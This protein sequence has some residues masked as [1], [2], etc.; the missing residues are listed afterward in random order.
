MRSLS[1][2]LVLPLVLPLCAQI[3]CGDPTAGPTG[4]QGE[5]GPKGDPGPTGTLPAQLV[6]VLP[7]TVFAE[8]SVQIQVSGLL[9]HFATGTTVRF[10]DPAITVSKIVVQGPGYLIAS[11]QAGSAV[12]L[13]AH[14][15]TVELARPSA[16]AGDRKPVLCPRGGAAGAAQSDALHLRAQLDS[17][18][19]G[20]GAV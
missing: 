1:L 7:S 20:D 8:R 17:G 4:P 10:D 11:I 18:P 12:R 19:V 2:R 5:P 3:S 9:T 15:I 6:G 16:G 13:G 14:D